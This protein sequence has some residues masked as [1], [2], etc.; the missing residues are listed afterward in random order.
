MARAAITQDSERSCSIICVLAILL[1]VILGI[2]IVY[3]VSGLSMYDKAKYA[4]R[5]FAQRR[6]LETL[7]V[8]RGTC[9]ASPRSVNNKQLESRPAFERRCGLGPRLSRG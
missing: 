5:V 8:R 9:S 2:D 1:T 7:N 4:H 6:H 3:D